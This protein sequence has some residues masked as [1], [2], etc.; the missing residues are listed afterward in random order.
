MIDSD[1]VVE[2]IKQY[3]KHGWILRRALLSHD[4]SSA[5]SGM[6]GEIDVVHSDLDG[7][8]FSRRSRPDSEAWELRRLTGLPFALVAAVPADATPEEVESILD[9]VVD[10]MRD[11]RIA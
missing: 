10:D 5:L 3:E 9:Q 7:L 2:I 4:N 6:L 1:A 11:R 8:W